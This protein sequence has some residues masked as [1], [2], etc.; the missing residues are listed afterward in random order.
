M[1]VA[2]IQNRGEYQQ[3]GKACRWSG[4]M[5]WEGGG[6]EGYMEEGKPGERGMEGGE[7]GCGGMRCGRGRGWARKFPSLSIAEHSPF[8]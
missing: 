6:D 5:R 2:C 7:Q 3:R 4:G 1:L 8:S